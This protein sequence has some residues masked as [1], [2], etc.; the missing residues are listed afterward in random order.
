MPEVA[1]GLGEE[2]NRIFIEAYGLQDELTPEVPLS[3]ITLTRNPHYR[4][5][6]NKTDDECEALLLSGSL[7]LKIESRSSAPVIC[8]TI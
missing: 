2:N 3:Q 8:R 1:V 7:S 6:N 4:Y 5:G